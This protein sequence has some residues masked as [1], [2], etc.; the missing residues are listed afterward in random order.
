MCNYTTDSPYKLRK[1]A[2]MGK[3]TLDTPMQLV[4]SNSTTPRLELLP[5]HLHPL[6]DGIDPSISLDADDLAKAGGPYH[7][8]PGHV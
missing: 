3:A 5:D 8:V 4:E 7:P 6:I 2:M 1:G